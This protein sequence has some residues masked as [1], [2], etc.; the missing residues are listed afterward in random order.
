MPAVSIRAAIAGLL[1]LPL[2]STAW[3]IG[4]GETLKLG[5]LSKQ[6]QASLRP[7]LTLRFYRPD[8]P[9]KPIDARRVRLAALHLGEGTAP[10]P[11]IEPGR[12]T[13]KLSGYIK[14]ALKGDFTL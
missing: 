5:K 10:S 12:F 2:A 9:D 3:L 7:G 14:T 11:F 13:A 4:G 6:E 1:I 8:A